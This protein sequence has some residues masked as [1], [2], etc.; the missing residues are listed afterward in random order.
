V[1]VGGGL[2]AVVVV[3]AELSIRLGSSVKELTVAVLLICEP[4]ASAQSTLATSVTVSDCPDARDANEILRL[5][6]EPPHTPPPVDEHDTNV[7]SA[8]RV[9]VTVTDVA[10]SGPLFVTVIV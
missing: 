8:G 2:E 5:L 4:S 9:S 6:F 1:I 7:V 3:V 10:A